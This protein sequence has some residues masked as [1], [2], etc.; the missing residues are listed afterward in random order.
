MKKNLTCSHALS[1]STSAT[2]KYLRKKMS[3]L[4]PKRPSMKIHS[5][6]NGAFVWIKMENSTLP[7]SWWKRSFDPRISGSKSASYSHIKWIKVRSITIL[8][9]QLTKAKPSHLRSIRPSRRPIIRSTQLN[10]EK[11]PC[12]STRWICHM[13]LWPKCQLRLIRTLIVIMSATKK[14]H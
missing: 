12:C 14:Y 9:L 8:T 5:F 2:P 6:K 11:C 4:I 13:A 3:R 10:K 1:L 7:M